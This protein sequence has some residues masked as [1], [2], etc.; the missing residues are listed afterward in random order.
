[1]RARCDPRG[2]AEPL[3]STPLTGEDTLLLLGAPAPP[4]PPPPPPPTPTPTPAVAVES[5][6]MLPVGDAAERLLGR[7]PR[8]AMLAAVA[9]GHAART[10][11]EV[12]AAGG[13]AEVAP[14]V[15]GIHVEKMSDDCG[16]CFGVRAAVD[17]F[18]DIP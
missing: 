7:L 10:D 5:E 14:L 15:E 13:L 16:D 18:C 3:E 9:A 6:P 2:A 17:D 11:A 12:G 4:P 1:M 8:P